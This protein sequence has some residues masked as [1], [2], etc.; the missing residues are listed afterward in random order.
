MLV[1]SVQNVLIASKKSYHNRIYIHEPKTKYLK[2]Y[3]KIH[4]LNKI[5]QNA[6]MDASKKYTVNVT[7][8]RS[9]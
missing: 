8:S 4:E 3:T 1:C 7:K 9:P 6:L 5:I 2:E